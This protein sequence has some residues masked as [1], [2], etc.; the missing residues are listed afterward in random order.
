MFT[1]SAIGLPDGPEIFATG[2]F[3][4]GSDF[5]SAAVELRVCLTFCP[6]P[7]SHRLPTDF[8]LI[9]KAVVVLTHGS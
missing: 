2:M 4:S 3:A 5:A 1:A 7:S 9:R 6:S 8:D